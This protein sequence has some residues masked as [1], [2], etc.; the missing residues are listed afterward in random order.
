V[1]VPE[2]ILED[3]VLEVFCLR[4]LIETDGAVYKDRGYPLVVFS[5]VI[6]QLAQ[7]VDW[8]I[9]GLGFRPHL[10]E[11]QP[12]AANMSTKHQ[13]RLSREVQA[14]LTLVKPLKA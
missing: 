6:L 5:S 10:Y 7:Q 9:R 4:G 14:F 2:W 11:I 1:R 13:V 12:H 8:M 3:R